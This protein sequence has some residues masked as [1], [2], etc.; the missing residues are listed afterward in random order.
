MCRYLKQNARKSS[1]VSDI[2]PESRL[3]LQEWL[4]ADYQLYNHFVKRLDTLIDK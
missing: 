1:K 2:S 3:Q 4:K